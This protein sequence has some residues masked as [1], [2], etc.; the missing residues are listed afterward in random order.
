MNSKV[1]ILKGIIIN[2]KMH[3]SAIVVIERLI[4]HP[5]YKKFIKKQTKLH[6]HDENNLCSNGDIVE[7]SQCKPISRTKSWKLVKIIKKSIF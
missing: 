2:N 7:I 4:K 1:C 6:I 5:I 3:K